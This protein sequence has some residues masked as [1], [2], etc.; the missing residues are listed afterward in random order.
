MVDVDERAERKTWI[1]DLFDDLS[2]AQVAAGALAAVT[3]MLLASQI[4]IA[5]SV[6]GAAVGSVVATVSSQVYKKFIA[7][8][9]EKI[10]DFPA[11]VGVSSGKADASDADRQFASGAS[12][13]ERGDAAASESPDVLAFIDP[14]LDALETQCLEPVVE[15]ADA[16]R[17][18]AHGASFVVSGNP[19]EAARVTRVTRADGRDARMFA[20][21]ELYR[22]RAERERIHRRRRVIG[23]SILS[24]LVA[25]AVSALI[26]SALTAGEG[27]GSKP[28]PLLEGRVATMEQR[29]EDDVDSDSPENVEPQSTQSASSSTIVP[30]ASSDQSSASSS[31]SAAGNSSSSAA[32]S[33]ERPPESSA[34]SDAGSSSRSSSGADAS[35]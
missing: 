33:G 28:A 14:S 8:S 25:V 11:A 26:V 5:G 18:R 35:A 19:R 16:S 34:S 23:V 6:I 4:G 7:A 24:A 32:S 31:S 29:I 17:G 15:Q 3:S 30:S 12:D 22:A 2:F 9:A 20:D 21:E 27:L 13:A 1:R 10:R